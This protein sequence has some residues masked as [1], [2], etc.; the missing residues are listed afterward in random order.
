[1]E[2]YVEISAEDCFIGLVDAASYEGFIG[3]EVDFETLERHIV[4]QMQ[5][6]R[7]LFWGAPVPNRWTLRL[8]NKA[9]APEAAQTFHGYVQITTGSLQVVNY[10][11]LLEAAEFEE[12]SLLEQPLDSVELPKGWYKITVCQ[13][14]DLTAAQLQEESLGY[15]II[16]TPLVQAP[17]TPSNS[18]KSIPWS[19]Y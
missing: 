15:E 16:C 14:I 12:D 4:E 18:F 13:L 2:H 17:P 11:A 10:S 3:G 9:Q 6:G 1:M 7:L 5:Q 19:I 8:T